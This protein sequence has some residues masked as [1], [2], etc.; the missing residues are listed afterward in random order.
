MSHDDDIDRELR[1]HID[2]RTDELIASGM[3]PDE[4]R[5]QARLE[6]GGVMQTKEAVRDLGPWSI[7][8]GL[9]QDCR[10]AFR[11]LCAT[12]IVTAV[13]ILSLAL[14]IGANTAMFSLVNSL[15][16]RALPV[17]DPAR[18]VLLKSREPEGYPEWSYVFWS[19]IRRR[20]QLFETSAAW[21][22]TARA[23]F[24]VAGVT[25]KADGF[26]ASGSF[27]DTL[28]VTALVGRTFS[29]ADDRR[30]GG[31]DGPVAV[32]SHRFWL[33]HFDGAAT[34]IGRT[35]TLENVPFT[36]V[37]VMPPEFFGADVG[38]T[39]DV[40]VPL[41]TEPMVSR[42]ESRLALPGTP[43]L[44]IV[45]RLKPDQT[46]D[47]ATE[48]V[49]GVRQQILA[50]TLPPDW[51]KNAQDEYRA[52]VLRLTPA[53]TGDSSVRERYQQPL[54]TI[55]V[56]VVL[57]LVIACANIAN[58]LLARG[59]ARRHE[60]SLR[61]ALGASRWRLVRQLFTE[62][63]V[64]AGTGAGLGIVLAAWGSRFLLSQISTEVR[65]VFLDLSMDRHVLLFTIGVAIATALLF[66]VAPALQA[67]SVAPMEAMKDH[68]TRHS[69]AGGR[70]GGLAS[71]LVVAQVALSLMLVVAAGLFVRTFASLATRPLGFDRDRVLVAAVNAHSA[72]IDPSQR[73]AFYERAR[74]AVGALPGVASAAVSY[75]TPPVTMISI[76]P[77]NSISGGA[78]LLGM[79]RM[80]A[81]NFV[82]PGWFSTFGT[83]VTTGRDVAD[84]DRGGAP[85]VALANQAFARKFLN[86]ASPLGHTIASTAGSPPAP[87]SIEIIG[88]V[89]DAVFG[90]LRAPVHPMLYLPMA[91]TD[92]L[93]PNAVAQMDL[94]VRSEG[95]PS[96]LLARTVTAAIR[97]V[98][99]NLVVTSRSLTDQ[100][101]A[102]LTQERV[103]AML[104]GF[105]GA[106][107]LLLAGLG[108]YGVTSYAVSRRRTEIGIRMAL[109]AA[110]ASVVRLVL[111]RV[112]GLV[113]MGVAVGAGISLW[114][115][116]FV[117]A[118]LYGL[119]PGDPVTLIGAVLVLGAVGAAAGWLPAFRASRIDPAEVLRDC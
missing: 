110:P 29:E 96:A 32:I 103:V 71:G 57:V 66:G 13:A 87:L 81:V 114:A 100:V 94:S 8:N 37:G 23:N 25:S 3:A 101:N 70:R 54:L 99:P 50:A 83:R 95:T 75:D 33:R 80:S 11:T 67:S 84:R 22:P 112:T 62:S 38:R 2:E 56:V 9:L 19:E 92:W 118:L 74:Q 10:L 85:R 6:L 88:V 5:R 72:A 43:F 104:S 76:I 20:P 18:L 78:T 47:A 79:E 17:R 91:Q 63:A 111:S 30:G 119:E 105:F 7:A 113:A 106:L 68:A 98:N 34:A 41:N 48:G 90:S 53:A 55:M 24:T 65:P 27:F 52:R 115:S 51:P 39:F 26:L 36:V 12:P 86:G 44:N 59:I 58:L 61:L 4:A 15:M 107:A 42:N 1:F 40:I 46:L 82:S 49:R 109:G 60:L 77:I 102:T 35:V 45:A 14:G 69:S 31:S 108:L 93:P 89:E 16:L 97:D 73:Q 28:G 117:A 21:S 116:K 64:L